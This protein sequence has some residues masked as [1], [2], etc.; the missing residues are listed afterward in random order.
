MTDQEVW[1]CTSQI[2]RKN[3]ANGHW[4]DVIYWGGVN[5]ASVDGNSKRINEYARKGYPVDKTYLDSQ[6]AFSKAPLQGITLPCVL[7]K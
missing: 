1:I 6:K 3:N 2:S 5:T 7:W 4:I